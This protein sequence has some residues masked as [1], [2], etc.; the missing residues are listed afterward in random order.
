MGIEHTFEEGG[1]GRPGSEPEVLAMAV[2]LAADGWWWPDGPRPP[3]ALEDAPSG[4]RAGAVGPPAGAGGGRPAP[5]VFRRRRAVAAL[6]LAA[7]LLAVVTSALGAARAPSGHAGS[8]APPGAA[9]GAA[10]GGPL[11]ATGSPTTPLDIKPA[12]AHVW[13]AR[14]GDTI[15]G[16]VTGSGYRGDPRPIVDRLTAELAGRPLQPGMRLTLP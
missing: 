7:P 8:S 4:D 10:G 15:W 11:T 12:V 5:E 16:I 3:G 1:E 2:A 6:M 9:G 13:V 14:P